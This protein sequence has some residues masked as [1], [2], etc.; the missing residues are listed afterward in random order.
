MAGLTAL[1]ALLAGG[2][3]PKPAPVQRVPQELSADLA[4][5]PFDPAIKPKYVLYPSDKLMIRYPTDKDL[6]QEVSIRSDGKITLPYV[7]EIQAAFRSPEELA[8][9][10]DEKSRVVLTDPQVTVIVVEEVS[11]VVFINGQVRVPGMVPL[12]PSQTLAQSVIDAG[13]TIATANADQVLII[14]SVPNDANYVLSTNLSK[15]LAGQAPDI[16]LEPYDVVH[17]P[18]TVIARV[19]LFMEQYVNSLIPRTVSFPFITQL[20][21]A[22]LKIVDANSRSSGAAAR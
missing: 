13:G 4:G 5:T 2:C 22:S 3:G 18:E 7:G 12:R 1:A 8:K 11:R 20:H 14:R 17:V 10:I 9:E 6:D 19:D 15:I 16:R 21:N